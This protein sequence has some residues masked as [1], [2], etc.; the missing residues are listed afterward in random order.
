MS[1]PQSVGF[2]LVS[3]VVAAFASV[4]ALSGLKVVRNPRRPSDLADGEQV[5]I[6]AERVDQQTD[7]SGNREK[8]VRSFS[9]G[10]L[11]RKDDADADA[12]ALAEVVS[13]VTHA[14]LVSMQTT[15]Q[16][17]QMKEG[18]VQFHVDDLEVDGAIVMSGW[19]IHYTRKRETA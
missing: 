11:S 7:K 14:A 17:S 16:I 10:A 19:E 15:S 13:N 4:P 6:V 9:V 12:D 1:L 2:E 3:K 5:I 8:R 18:T